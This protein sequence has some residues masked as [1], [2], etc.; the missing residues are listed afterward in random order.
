MSDLTRAALGECLTTQKR[1]GEAER[2]LIS[3]YNDLKESQGAHT[4]RTVEALQRLA[5][6]Y[7]VWKKPDQAAHYRTLLP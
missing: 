7:D 2:L 5:L 6:L 3:S 4:P 1:Y